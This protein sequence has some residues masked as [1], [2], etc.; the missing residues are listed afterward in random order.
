MS[1]SSPA[2]LTDGTETGPRWLESRE[3]QQ[4]VLR[5]LALLPDSAARRRGAEAWPARVT[6]LSV[7]GEA[8]R[9]ALWALSAG[10]SELVYVTR[11]LHAARPLAL[12]TALGVGGVVSDDE[13]EFTLLRQVLDELE[14]MGD[15][16]SLPH[17]RW[18]PA[19]MRFVPLDAARR[20]VLLGG[21]PTHCLPAAL[22]ECLE[23]NGVARLLTSDPT[24]LGLSLPVQA[25]HDWTRA[26]RE[27][28]IEWARRVVEGA[29]VKPFEDAEASFEYYAP[30]KARKNWQ[31]H[32]WVVRMETLPDGRYLARQ[33]ARFGATSYSVVEVHQG[34]VVS[35]GAL[36]IDEGDVRRLMYGIDAL[37]GWS[38]RVDV[39]R[40]DA[41]WCFK[42][43]NELP[44]AEH[45]LLTA[46]G[47][48]RLPPGDAYYPRVWEVTGRYAVQAVRA[49][50]GLCVSLSGV[51]DVVE[52]ENGMETD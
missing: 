23:H 32:R 25:Q 24:R 4:S 17:G 29:K 26:P 20:W 34:S 16:A 27:P 14:A 31:F 39:S 11:L 10:G 5:N 47:R 40:R 46:I 37:T 36:G 38:V 30:A 8:L 13:A 44:S 33:T 18:L 45:R 22:L 50:R 12:P 19:P 28:L 52:L 9:S 43:R 41:A 7:R 15:V 42:L 2:D 48:L 1:R 49:L 51:E 35:T 3:M 6:P 21:C